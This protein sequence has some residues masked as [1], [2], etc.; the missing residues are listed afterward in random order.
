MSWQSGAKGISTGL[1]AMFDFERHA[2]FW[3]ELGSRGGA[4]AVIDHESGS[5]LTYR[6]LQQRV[7]K[8]AFELAAPARS[9]ILLF[10]DNEVGAIVCY[11]AALQAGHAVFLSPTGIE[12]SGVAALIETYRPERILWSSGAVG[13]SL[14]AQYEAARPVDDYQCLQRRGCEDEPLNPALSLVLSTSASTGSSKTVRLSA[15]NLAATAVQV[16]E[17]LALQSMDRSLLSLPL[18]YVYGLSVLNS[19]LQAG[20]CVVL[21]KG[22]F[23]D[24]AHQQKLSGSGVTTLPCVSQTLEYLQR[25]SFDVALLPDLRR[26]THAGSR[27]NPHLFA[28]TY[29]RFAPRRVDIYLM[30]G[31][32]EACGRISVL[33][34]HGLPELHQSVGRAMRSGALRIGRQGE[35][36]YEGPGVMLGYATRREDLALGDVLGGVLHTGDVGHLD[37][38]GNLFVVGRLSR[39]AKVFGR[40]VNLD[41]VERSVRMPEPAA[42]VEKDGV[43]FICHAGAASASKAEIERIAR[44]LQLP[45]QCFRLHCV[46][47]LPRNARGKIAYGALLSMVEE[48]S[49]A[50]R[51]R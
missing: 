42:A 16:A 39:F 22:T 11:L 36:I 38:H 31:Q 25:S 8:A 35:I 14:M 28:W 43:I 41:D 30:Y 18:S 48:T 19:S 44:E 10:A 24:R 5:M 27:L 51:W 26:L 50:I 17:A 47:T 45:P 20:A 9:L 21:L 29:E 23:A 6:Q 37:E 49:A 3:E 13:G 12:H 15:A 32:T 4:P 46:S 40:R 1:R 7:E 34:P 33:Q 2:P